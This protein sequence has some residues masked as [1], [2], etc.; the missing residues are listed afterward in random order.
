MVNL[1]SRPNGRGFRG[2]SFDLGWFLGALDRATGGH[3]S[4]SVSSIGADYGGGS[5]SE[6]TSRDPGQFSVE[7]LFAEL[8][9]KY[10]D[11]KSS[12]ER[13]AAGIRKFHEAETLCAQTNWRLTHD[14]STFS[15]A[16]NVHSVIA[17]ASRKIGSVLG[18]FSWD[19]AGG[20]FGFGPG[21]TYNLPRT[22]ADK[23][24]KYSGTP[25]STLGNAAAS[26]A[27]LLSSPLWLQG[28][29]YSEK[30]SQHPL[31]L[32]EW[33]P[34]NRIVT[35][36]KNHKGDRT[37][38]IEPRL[39]MYVQK[40]IGSMIRRR[41]KRVKVDLDD[42]SVN[43]GLASIASSFGLAT[44]DLSMASDTV[45]H[46]VVRKLLPPDWYEALEQCRSPVGV[47]PSGEIVHYQKFSS[48]GNGYT[49]ELESLI[50]WAICA[51]V[52]EIHGVDGTLVW[53]YGDDLII[54]NQIVEPLFDT[55][56]FLG[57][58]PNEKKSHWGT[59]D[60]R[61]SCGKHYFQG[62]DVT[63]FYVK[64][65]VTTLHDLF[66]LHNNLYRWCLRNGWNGEWDRDLMLGLLA[67]LRAKAPSNWR[68]PRIPDLVG[69]G[70]FMGT[71]DQCT[72]TPYGKGWEA[73]RVRVLVNE[74]AVDDT[75]GLGRL[76]KTLAY[77]EGK[78]E[79]LFIDS[80][81]RGVAQED[82]VPLPSCARWLRFPCAFG[83]YEGGVL[84]APRNRIKKIAVKQY[85]AHWPS[86]PV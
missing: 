35:V 58:V 13:A 46:D 34:G 22:K 62:R 25:E 21:A 57:F 52:C 6:P 74:P 67:D 56:S 69:D 36:P 55:L 53:V 71:F 31:D 32:I 30:S 83:E 15:T 5:L 12:E 3:H 79:E 59:D 8:L 77:L 49:F 2:F 75:D 29:E 17:T 24:Y 68:K 18:E 20:G 64:R 73:Y 26:L 66:L 80:L 10:D 76:C 70:A 78:G 11:G 51:S 14:R 43:Q 60:Y 19:E 45:S 86:W 28:L 54:P 61:E 9:S 27:V 23:S 40:G 82:F 84:L 72:P 48:M 44:I 1:P 39:N 41:L 50:F 85:P 7:L 47:L 81:R 38:A 33:V 16:W 42:Q 37:I 4:E 65:K 63:P